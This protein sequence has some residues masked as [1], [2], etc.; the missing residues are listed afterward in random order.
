MQ[1]TDH[2]A[3]ALKRSKR[4]LN[5]IQLVKKFFTQKELL[6][7]ITSILYYTAEIWH[8]PTLKTTLKQKLLSASAKAL[9]VSTKAI[10][11]NQSFISLH[12]M[13]NRATPETFIQYKSALC[14]Y[15]LYNKNYNPIEFAHLNFNQVLMRRQVHFKML[16]S[17]IYKVGNNSLAN[18]LYHINDQIPLTWLNASFSTFKV[19]CKRIYLN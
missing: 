11:Y 2:L 8:L 18:R 15:K 3:H 16:K 17:N 6:S 7:L 9:G 14:L 5:E 10:D 12:A 4:A 1:W 19:N 13:C